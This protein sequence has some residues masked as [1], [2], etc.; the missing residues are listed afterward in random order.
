MNEQVDKENVVHT[1]TQNGIL[2]SH[3]NCKTLT[4]AQR[5]WTLR[6]LC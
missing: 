4:F 6:A 1:H 3:D 2:F 5:R